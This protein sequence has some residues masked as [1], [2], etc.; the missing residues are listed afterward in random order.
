MHVIHN[1]FAKC[2]LQ[3]TG[4]ATYCA[5]RCFHKSN[6]IVKCYTP[7]FPLRDAQ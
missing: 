3:N 2:V 7:Y 4:V 6:K 1:Q 5:Q